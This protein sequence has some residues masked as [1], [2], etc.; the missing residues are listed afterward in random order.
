MAAGNQRWLKIAVSRV[1]W[2]E[3]AVCTGW[4]AHIFNYKTVFN[5]GRGGVGGRGGRGGGGA[6]ARISMMFVTLS[7]IGGV[8]L[9]HHLLSTKGRALAAAVVSCNYDCISH[10]SWCSACVS[11][12]ICHRYQ[13]SPARTAIHPSATSFEKF[14]S[15]II[16]R[17]LIHI[18]MSTAGVSMSDSCEPPPQTARFVHINKTSWAVRGC[19]V[20]VLPMSQLR[21]KCH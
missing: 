1:F 6:G 9:W 2:T 13:S 20:N 12:G 11:T 4:D 14:S 5:G 18:C 10:F 19:R 16:Q 3:R 17:A 7:L 8:S 21:E 15:F